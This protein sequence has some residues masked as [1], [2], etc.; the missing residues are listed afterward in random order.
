MLRRGTGDHDN[1][2]GFE[3]VSIDPYGIEGF[4]VGRDGS[5][6]PCAVSIASFDNPCV[7][8][9]HGLLTYATELFLRNRLRKIVESLDVHD[10]TLDLTYCQAVDAIGLSL[11]VRTRWDLEQIGIRLR[12]SRPT[13][14]VKRVLDLTRVSEIFKV[15]G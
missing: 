8:R 5:N 12:V 3:H 2:P 13:P 14:E 9:I 10:L 6:L 11:L 15:P 7:I 1:I 4:A